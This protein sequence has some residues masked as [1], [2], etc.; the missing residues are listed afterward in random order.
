MLRVQVPLQLELQKQ[1]W[2]AQLLQRE[3][4]QEQEPGSVPEKKEELE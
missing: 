4:K 2:M 1:A 3:W